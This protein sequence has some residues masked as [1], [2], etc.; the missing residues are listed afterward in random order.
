MCVSLSARKKFGFVDGTIP[1]PSEES[2]DLEDWWTNNA[3]VVSWIKLTIDPPL[4][5]SI[6][7]R[8]VAYDLWE[9]IKKQFSVKNGQR[10]QR[11]KVELVTCRQRGS[12]IEE[13]YGK[14]MS[15]WTSL[16]DHRQAKNCGCPLGYDLEK[17]R[18]EDRLHE[19]FM[20]IDESV[21]SAV[22]SNLLSRDPLPSL[23]EAS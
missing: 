1:K 2:G 6:S 15:L 5:T 20:G 4:R 23:D 7:H 8:D 10:V 19:F 16:A 11:L 9:A 21:Y 14:M 18:E 3:L 12:T 13:Y 17:E 22:K